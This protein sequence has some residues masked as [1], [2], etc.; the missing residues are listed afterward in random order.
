MTPARRSRSE[1]SAVRR[2]R[3][4]KQTGGDHPDGWLSRTSC[5]TTKLNHGIAPEFRSRRFGSNVQ[6]VRK[7]RSWD[8]RPAHDGDGVDIELHATCT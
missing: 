7:S 5:R 1:E 6:A 4:D 3:A 8:G 2:E